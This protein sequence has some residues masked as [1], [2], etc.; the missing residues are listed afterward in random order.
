[1]L[2]EQILKIL[3]N[4]INNVYGRTYITRKQ[5]ENGISKIFLVSAKINEKKN[6]NEIIFMLEDIIKSFGYPSLDKYF[7][8]IQPNIHLDDINNLFVYNYFFIP[9]SIYKTNKNNDNKLINTKKL[10]ESNIYFN[11]F[12]HTECSDI[13]SKGYIDVKEVELYCLLN[14]NGT[15]KE[16]LDSKKNSV[17]EKIKIMCPTMNTKFISNFFNVV[18]YHTLITLKENELINR[19][20]NYYDKTKRLSKMN[21]NKIMKLMIDIQ[22][23]EIYENF[24]CLMLGNKQMLMNCNSILKYFIDNGNQKFTDR[25]L[26]LFTNYS[27]NKMNYVSSNITKEI[28]TIKKIELSDKNLT[29]EFMSCVNIPKN[30]KYIA[31]QKISEC[32]GELDQKMKIYIKGLIDFPWKP[33]NNSLLNDKLSTN[34]LDSIIEKMNEKIHGHSD[35]KNILIQIMAKWI[36]NPQSSGNI[37]GLTG[38]PGVGKTSFAKIMG[39]C[40]NVPLVHINMGGM[41]DISDLLGHSFTYVNSQYGAIIRKMIEAGSHRCILYFDE[42]DKVSSTDIHNIL[43]HITDPIM[44]KNF[45][46]RFYTSSINF[47][48]SSVLIV[49][50]YN[51][52]NKLSEIFLDRINEIE[53]PPPGISDKIIISKKY[54]MNDILQ[55]MGINSDSI[56]IDNETLRYLI[57]EFTNEFGVRDLK[58]KLEKIISNV[59]I[60]RIRTNCI[61][62]QIIIDK[63][64]VDKCLKKNN[65]CH[66]N[67]NMFNNYGVINGLY[68]NNSSGGGVIQFQI[69]KN[70]IPNNNF[71]LI[72]GNQKQIM[73]ESIKC[74]LNVALD[75]MEK[76][77]NKKSSEI[78]TEY[79]LGFHIHVQDAGNPK[80]GPSGGAAF[81]IAFIS[82]FTKKVLDHLVAITGEIDIYGNIL[83]IGNLREKIYGA[84]I[85]KI[86]TVYMPVDN[87]NELPD[88]DEDYKNEINIIPVKNIDELITY[89]I[90]ID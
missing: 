78:F 56:N 70:R 31:M 23:I 3:N 28:E 79:D 75:I 38:Y 30:V 32:S 77:F 19:V 43:I 9:I 8:D 11:I 37:I 67:I 65:I 5:M 47:D 84:Y 29:E 40:L 24:V 46:D 72:T 89:L 87:I 63:N 61:S 45:Q 52:R 73:I 42:V 44:N 82:L 88:V 12:I 39:D 68:A 13:I 18:G 15:I 62:K 49:F 54:F 71:L 69:S 36:T 41:N 7:V 22:L 76:K 58:R 83:K 57:K 20:I 25:L 21:I 26:N 53:L 51:D 6:Q 10:D 59:N 81:V 80:D 48:L 50:S 60:E 4:H 27:L 33:I 55:D 86:K 34:V 90:K 85:N 1:M 2:C 74:A 17:I 14:K 16:F 66:K 64:F 35:V